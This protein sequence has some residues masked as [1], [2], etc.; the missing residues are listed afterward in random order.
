MKSI[1]TVLLVLI[2]S[3]SF[4]QINSFH[5]QKFLL[6]HPNDQVSF[7][8]EN[9][10]LKTLQVLERHSM[11]PIAITK[12][13]VFVSASPKWVK[14]KSDAKEIGY[15]YFEKSRPKA[16]MDST[17]AKHQI[18]PLHNGNALNTVLK[19][20]NVIVGYLDN[21]LD[22]RHLDFKDANGATRVKYYWNQGL[23]YDNAVPNSFLYG[24]DYDSLD[25]E[26]GLCVLNN[27]INHGTTV[28]G[29]GSG[30]GLANGLNI[31][32]APKSQIIIVKTDENRPNW[33]ITVAEACAYV[34]EKADL[35]GLPAV[36][37]ISYG[38]YFGSHDQY[39]PATLMMEG[40]LDA[41]RGRSIV[42]AAGNAGNIGKWH[43]DFDKPAADTACVWLS[44]FASG[45]P[46]LSACY[47]DMWA[48]ASVASNLKV[49][50]AVDKVL[51]AVSQ[52]MTTA[53]MNVN[54][55]LG[56]YITTAL[57]LG[58]QQFG[59][60]YLFAEIVNGRFHLECTIDG[61]DSS[62]YKF[63]FNT[64]GANGMD[65]WSGAAFGLSEF[66]DNPA[67]VAS[68]PVS[69][70]YEFPDRNK[71][72][73][74]S[75]VN[76][77]H[78]ITVA[79]VG[80]R[81]SYIDVNGNTY[82]PGT[83]TTPYKLS[84][85]SSKGPTRNGLQKPDVNACGDMTLSAGPLYL[86]PGDPAYVPGAPSNNVVGAGGM[87][88]RNGGTSIASPVIAGMAAL[89]LSYCPSAS[90]QDIKK[91]LINA[92]EPT[93]YS[94]ILP[95]YGYGHGFPNALKMFDSLDNHFLTSQISC[96]LPS[97][98]TTINPVTSILW[99]TG[100][101]SPSIQVNTEA[102]VSAIAYDLGRCKV[103]DTISV[104]LSQPAFT[105]IITSLGDSLYSIQTPPAT[106]TITWLLNG[107]TIGT[108][109]QID[110]TNQPNGS[111]VAVNTSAT[112]CTAT[113]LVT[114]VTASL[115]ISYS[116]EFK[117]YPNPST[118]K[119]YYE[120]AFGTEKIVVTD[121]LGKIMLELNL[122]NSSGEI[123]LI[124]AP[125]GIYFV[126]FNKNGEQVVCKIIKK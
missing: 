115:N 58:A 86:L 39:D 31:G 82:F 75:W 104:V 126:R 71:T 81:T 116:K 113:S 48:D 94:G 92:A 91:A 66:V 59:T 22:Y 6:D 23:P 17:I 1:A 89:Y 26:N 98:V 117:V 99:S 121:V 54:T 33:T 57:T 13:W 93:T 27:T 123:N 46:G 5:F 14:E 108:G 52:R 96:N 107:N 68:L 102:E 61:I 100:A 112:N 47:F 72:M 38:E 88:V 34:F 24:K 12:E 67:L 4:G 74:S 55:N 95:N 53:F 16:L 105:P 2:F 9:E 77:D 78:I 64:T 87:H 76:S 10:G 70:I 60:A 114:N 69:Y 125:K 11:K 90:W 42:A 97:A 15:V 111:L 20:E 73:V 7:A 101:T 45:G 63:R 40:L 50:I 120:L 43:I 109:N 29:V 122:P 41:K 49:S 51:P 103:F 83:V 36:M 18:A 84:V 37:N 25:I 44:P 119:F 65:A 19:G 106:G 62:Q 21:G 8:I 79:N 30:N 35:M 32:V 124:D 28:T 3:N 56:G 118:D 80:N 85:N 110:L